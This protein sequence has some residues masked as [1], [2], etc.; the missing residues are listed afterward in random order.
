MEAT[1]YQMY[2]FCSN[3]NTI[4]IVTIITRFQFISNGLTDHE[5]WSCRVAAL[6]VPA[7]TCVTSTDMHLFAGFARENG[8]VG[9]EGNIAAA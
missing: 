8:W 5:H 1:R 2:Q 6:D 3:S 4:S 7:N 9:G